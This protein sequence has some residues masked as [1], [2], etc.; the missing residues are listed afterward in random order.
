LKEKQIEGLLEKIKGASINQKKKRR[1]K[2][3]KNIINN[4]LNAC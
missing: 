1:K 4:K 3:A 2:K